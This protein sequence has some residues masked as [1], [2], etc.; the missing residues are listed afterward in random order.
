MMVVIVAK[1]V[2]TRNGTA[3]DGMGS[4]IDAVGL[5]FGFVKEISSVQAA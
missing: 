2:L 5:V 3:K 4:Y 1:K